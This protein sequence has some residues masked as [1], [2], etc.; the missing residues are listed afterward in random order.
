MKSRDRWRCIA[1]IQCGKRKRA[2][3][4]PAG[5]L[6]TGS[7]FVKSLKYARHRGANIIYVL[8][9]E[10]GL[11]DLQSEVEPYEKNLNSMSKGER[12]EWGDRVIEQLRNNT[13]LENDRFLVLASKRYRE[14]LRGA[15]QCM[16]V[17]MVGLRQGEQLRFLTE[18]V[19]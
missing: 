13:D 11:L 5:Q 12:R 7:L 2:V 17:P 15:L 19:K 9:A 14:G 4:S 8:S 16:E 1:L 3:R 10:H 18:A 6:Y